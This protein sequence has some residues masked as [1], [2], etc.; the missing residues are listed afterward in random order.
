MYEKIEENYGLFDSGVV[1]LEKTQ[2]VTKYQIDCNTPDGTMYCYH[3]FQ[4]IDLAYTTFYANSCFQRKNSLPH[5]IEIAYCRSGR[6]ECE[7]KRGFMTYL[8]ENDLAVSII[9]SQRNEPIF[10]TGIYEGVALI[11]NTDIIG[12]C[13]HAPVIGIEIDFAGLIQKFCYEQCCV[14]MKT[15][16]ELLHVFEEICDCTYRGNLGYLRLKAL[17]IFFLLSNLST[18]DNIETSAYY[19]G[20]TIAKVKALKSALM[21]QLDR[22]ISL[23]ELAEQYGLSLTMLKDCFKAVYGKPVHAFRREY[24]MQVATKL[25]TTTDMSITELAGEFGYEN[26]NKFS[27]AFKEVIGVSP[28]AYRAKN[29]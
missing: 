23:P 15:P 18:Q 14:V 22:K 11:I 27:T 28:R 4:G 29:K 16:P 7:Y 17:E 25:L 6:Y 1:V 26:P 5:I 13:F 9:N 8:G 10:P 2:N 21:E 19:S 3:L 24:K 12:E 20:E